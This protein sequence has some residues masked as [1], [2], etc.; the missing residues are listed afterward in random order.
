[1]R[2]S[3]SLAAAATGGERVGPDVE[4]EGA[5]FDSRT[6]RPGQLFVP[7]V[8]ERDG[9]EFVPAAVAA[10]APAYLTARPVDAQDAA[11]PTATAILVEDTAAA[12]LDLGRWGRD[13]LAGLDGRVVGITGSVGKT[14]V[15]DLTAAALGA[16]WRTAA[17]PRSYNNEQG[18]P[19]TVLDADD[20]SEALVLEMGMRGPG[21]IAR[22]CQI[23]RPAV[24]VVTMVAAAHTERVG[25]LDGVARA[26]AELVDS[27]PAGGVAVLNA[28]DARVLA[29]A[30][31]APGRVLTFGRSPAA[32]VA[33][34]DLV[35][36]GD[37][38][39]AEFTV[40]TPWGRAPVR[41]AVP[42]AH[43]AVNAAAAIA[44]ALVCDVTLDDAAA[45]VGR[46]TVSPWRMELRRTPG[47]ALVLNDAYNANPTSMRAAL[48]TLAALPGPSRRA[49]VGVMAELDDPA[50][51]HLAIA[52]EASRLDIELI[53]V[54]TDLY[55]VAPV[56]DPV[57]AV[58]PLGPGLAV[59]VK[60]SRVAGLEAVVARLLEG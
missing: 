13:R 55:G 49:V 60:G 22:L 42:G 14:S 36:S 34:A 3:A 6:L 59:L 51:E 29:M 2:F 12:L 7:L 1:M 20:A 56:A 10:G 16:R 48:A 43:M 41:L 27:L 40:M 5:S 11:T 17:N 28:D 39:H 9:H 33:V 44:V 15:K 47:G 54:G 21:E 45:A 8:A 53:A 57:A 30:A 46:A 18:L 52:A 19:V 26:K 38:A 58:G 24:G 35:L 31:R 32:D 25:G 50:R 23:G 4:L 37:E